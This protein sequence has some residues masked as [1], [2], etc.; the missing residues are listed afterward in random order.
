MVDIW[1]D[2]T[3]T[4]RRWFSFERVVVDDGTNAEEAEAEA[5]NSVTLGINSKGIRSQTAEVMADE[6][7]IAEV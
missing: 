6:R 1:R 4:A 3:P 5:G 2:F 7:N